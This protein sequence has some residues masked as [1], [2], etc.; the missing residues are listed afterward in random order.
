MKKLMEI[1]KVNEIEHFKEVSKQL[2]K[3]SILKMKELCEI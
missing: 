2:N 3:M 1:D